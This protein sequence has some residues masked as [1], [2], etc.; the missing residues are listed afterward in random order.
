MDIRVQRSEPDDPWSS[1]TWPVRVSG[2]DEIGTVIQTGAVG[3]PVL[4]LSGHL[5]YFESTGECVWYLA[6]RVTRVRAEP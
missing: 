4:G 6:K 5:V 1:R 2:R 3:N